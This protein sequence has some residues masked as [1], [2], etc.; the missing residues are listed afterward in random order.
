MSPRSSATHRPFG[1]DVSSSLETAPGIKSFD[2]MRRF[3]EAAT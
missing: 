3:I 1:V 2:A